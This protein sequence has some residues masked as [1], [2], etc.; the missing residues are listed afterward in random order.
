MKTGE[1]PLFLSCLLLVV[2]LAHSSTV[3][4]EVVRASETSVNFELCLLLVYFA[5]SLLGL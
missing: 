2:C 5:E 4:M 3:K 1:T